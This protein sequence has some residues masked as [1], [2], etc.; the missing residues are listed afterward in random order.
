VQNLILNYTQ[1][2]EYVMIVMDGG[3]ARR[4][5]VAVVAAISGCAVAYVRKHNVLAHAAMHAGIRAAANFAACRTDGLHS[6]PR[7]TISLS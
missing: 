5:D 7:F 4:T 6:E 2:T 3:C 1:A